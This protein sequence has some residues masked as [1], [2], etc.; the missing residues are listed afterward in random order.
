VITSIVGIFAGIGGASHG[1]GEMLQGNIAP[2]DVMIK[3]WPTL[4]ALG[5]EPAMTIL[6]SLLA[7]GI[8]TIILGALVAVWAGGF[9]GRKNAGLLLILLSTVMLLVGGG[10]VPPIFGIAAGIMG[11][12]GKYKQAKL[13]VG[14]MTKTLIGKNSENQVAAIVKSNSYVPESWK[15]LLRVGAI[16]ALI[17]ALVFRRNL[18]VAEIPLFTGIAAPTTVDGWFTLIH[19]NALLGLTLLNVFDI[20]NYAFV[21]LMFL[22]F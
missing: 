17:A 3:A 21:G 16:A 15:S 9:G 14:N 11:I 4:T 18:G 13:E 1:P 2:N 8:F 20:A 5:G 12:L 6:P 22:A 7:A 10:I 19:S